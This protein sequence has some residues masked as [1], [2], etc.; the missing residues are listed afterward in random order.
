MEG[1]RLNDNVQEHVQ[2]ALDMFKHQQNYNGSVEFSEDDPGYREMLAFFKEK[3][4]PPE[5]IYFTVNELL[6]RYTKLTP[7]EKQFATHIVS[8]QKLIAKERDEDGG[9]FIGIRDLLKE[10]IQDTDR[11]EANRICR[12]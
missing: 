6:S 1:I 7:H 9:K 3:R 11:N 5:V 8:T 10:K 2:L 4:T 12:S